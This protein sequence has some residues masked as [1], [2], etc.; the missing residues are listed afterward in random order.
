MYVFIGRF[1]LVL[2]VWIMYTVSVV[3]TWCAVGSCTSN[4]RPILQQVTSGV[5][6]VLEIGTG[7]RCCIVFK[8]FKSH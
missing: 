1:P 2:L 8:V 7:S 4:G 6:P 5:M 3:V